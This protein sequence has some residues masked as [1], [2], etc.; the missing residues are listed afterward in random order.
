MLELNLSV[1]KSVYK[2]QDPI[3]ATLKI[4]NISNERIVVKKRFAPNHQFLEES[5]RDVAFLITDSLENQLPFNGYSQVPM[6]RE[7]HF[8]VLGPGES[9]EHSYSDIRVYYDISI[10]GQYKIQAVYE[11]QSDSNNNWVAWKGML[12]SNL[13]TIA[14]EP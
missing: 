3:K 9:I 11:N 1:D 14:I 5:F 10:P 12:E 7:D 4:S 2:A 13:V 6:L 8:I